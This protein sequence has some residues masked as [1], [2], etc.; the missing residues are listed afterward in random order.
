MI[1]LGRLDVPC[2]T[3]LSRPRDQKPR[4]HNFSDLPAPVS[5]SLLSPGPDI[6]IDPESQS[7]T[8]MVLLVVDVL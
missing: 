5:T 2:G 4:S 6:L 3:L 1:S 8:V 7:C